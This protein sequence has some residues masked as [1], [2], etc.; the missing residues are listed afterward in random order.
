M[1]LNSIKKKLITK[2]NCK[3]FFVGIINSL[4]GYCMGVGSYFFF[5]TQFGIIFISLL[6]SFF[7]ILFSFLMH[8]IY[9]FKTP[10]SNILKELIKFF[11][12]YSFNIIISLFLIIF[13]VE[14]HKINIFVSQIFVMSFTFLIGYFFSTKYIFKIK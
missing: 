10:M 4:F 5:Y 2:Y 9:V 12:L 6:S 14:I 1:L 11:V 7:S 3:Y 13:L 8:K